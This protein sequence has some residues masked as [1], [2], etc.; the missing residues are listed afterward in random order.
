MLKKRDELRLV[1][2]LADNRLKNFYFWKPLQLDHI[3]KLND[4]KIPPPNDFLVNN[5]N[6]DL[7]NILND[8]CFSHFS[9]LYLNSLAK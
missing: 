4:E 3:Q 7:S 5:N 9:L 2:I 6:S 1:D 8:F